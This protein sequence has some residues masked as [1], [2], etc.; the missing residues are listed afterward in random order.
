MQQ[1]MRVLQHQQISPEAEQ[2]AGVYQLG[3]PQSEYRVR[4]KKAIIILV[5]LAFALGALF[6]GTAF[7]GG[8]SS[9][10]VIFI[11]VALLF[12]G[13]GLYMALTPVI[14]RSWRVYVCADGFVFKR[15]NKI[16]AFRWD[17]IESM[18]QAVTRRYSY[19]VYTGS[20][21]KYTIRRKDGVQV[22]LNDRFADV[23]Q[24]GTTISQAITNL[25]LPQVVAAY[26]AGQTIAF[27]PFSISL[28]G[29]SNGQE[30]L[31]W[32]QIKEMGVKQGIVTV[33]K[34]GKWLN[35]STIRAS[36]VP[37]IFVF[38]ALVNYVLKNRQ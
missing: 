8:D 38:M 6:I 7:A 27:G 32:S 11:L 1:P 15:G 10:L 35:W 17:Q 23:E 13:G 20:T 22:V 29:V 24:L 28:Q 4:I 25:L 16:D 5:I 30:S 18:W 36:Q 34:E 14:Y 31:P 2:L 33:R 3:A 9:E 19:G 26:N 12:I 21:H 37:N